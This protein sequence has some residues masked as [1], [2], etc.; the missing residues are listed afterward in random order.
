MEALTSASFIITIFMVEVF[1][2]GVIL[3]SMKENGEQ[4]KCMV[5][6]FL[7]GLMG[8]NILESITKIKRKVLENLFFKMVEDIVENGLT[9][10]KLVKV[11]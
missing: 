8:E 9:V 1:T 10:N 4:T 7:V 5:K 11:H 6:G 3:G 2:L